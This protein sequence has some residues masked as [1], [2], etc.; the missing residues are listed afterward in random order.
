MGFDL[1]GIGASDP[2]PVTAGQDV[3][4]DGAGVDV[5][6]VDDSG[7]RADPLRQR[8]QA[9]EHRGEEDCLTHHGARLPGG[10]SSRI[11]KTDAPPGGY[12]GGAI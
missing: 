10:H 4:V 8:W 3:V 5:I 12:R 7:L 9:E 2:H 6:A 11:L 1:G